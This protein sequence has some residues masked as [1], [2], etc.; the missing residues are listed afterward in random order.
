MTPAVMVMAAT[1]TALAMMAAWRR[2]PPQQ[3]QQHWGRLPLLTLMRTTPP[4]AFFTV[5]SALGMGHHEGCQTARANRWPTT[6]RASSRRGCQC[7]SVTAAAIPSGSTAAYVVDGLH[8][9]RRLHSHDGNYCHALL[10]NL[11]DF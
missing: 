1:E 7:Q 11:L 8:H 9:R 6:V 10:D 3:V 5:K 2:L 4:G